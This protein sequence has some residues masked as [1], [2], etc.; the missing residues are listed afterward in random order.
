MAQ[1]KSSSAVQNC[2]LKTKVFIL[3]ASIDEYEVC[4]CVCVCLIKEEQDRRATSSGQG[5]TNNF[6]QGQAFC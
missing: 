1:C 3:V 5:Q 2:S 6:S 4:M